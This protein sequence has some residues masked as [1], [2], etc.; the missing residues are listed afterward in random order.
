[1]RDE[2]RI[3]SDSDRISLDDQ[4]DLVCDEFE[5]LLRA[6]QSPDISTHVNAASLTERGR[7]FLELLLV[8]RDFRSDQGSCPTWDEYRQRYP[9]FAPQIEEARLKSRSTVEDET[10]HQPSPEGQ[11]RLGQFVLLERLGAGAVGEVWKARDAALQRDVAIKIPLD[12]NLS[13]YDLNRF[14]R[15]ARTAGQLNDPGIVAVYETGRHGDIVYIVSA[16]IPGQDLRLRLRHWT[17]TPREAADICRR[18]AESLQHAHDNGIVHRD[19][20]PSNIIVDNAARPHITDFGLA[21]WR[22]DTLAMTVE[23]DVMGTPAYMSPEQARGHAAN[24]DHRTDIYSLGM[25][26]YE[27]LTG[28]CAFSG[29]PEAIT[30]KVLNEEPISPDLMRRGLPRDLVT[31]CLKALAKSPEGRYRSAQEMA[32]DLRRFLDGEPILARRVGRVEKSWRWVRKRPA[33]VV[34]FGLALIAGG[35]SLVAQ[36][37]AAENRSL[38]GLQTVRLA[39]DPPAEDIV[40]VPYDKFTG[41]AAP[42][43]ATRLHGKGTVK[44]DLIPG[45]Y[46]VV[47]R[48]ADGRFHEV[49]RYVPRVGDVTLGHYLHSQWQQLNDGTIELPTINIPPHSVTSGMALV[50]AASHTTKNAPAPGLAVPAFYMDTHEFTEQQWEDSRD[51]CPALAPYTDARSAGRGPAFA[52]TSDL[53]NAMYSAELVG[54]RL[55]LLE[56]Y[57]AALELIPPRGRMLSADASKL[58]VI[59]PVAS[60]TSDATATMPPIVGL[61]SNVAE[62]T[63]SRLPQSRPIEFGT[64]GVPDDYR[65]LFPS[66]RREFPGERT[67]EPET[68]AVARRFTVDTRL[69]F[70]C[71]RSAAPRYLDAEK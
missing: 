29:K 26:L 36:H 43:R 24:A 8:D 23:G 68:R 17:P 11:Q 55:P 3:I 6:G 10:Q 13:E 54:K 2:S 57:E 9:E 5:Q 28:R 44:L 30:Y 4:I 49:V 63:T 16:F 37:T 15:E 51:G 39:T 35:A 48:T 65:I 34:A 25:I 27:M 62:W 67:D 21:K 1:M 56:E 58:D 69:G 61:L 22:E 70:R 50:D 7:L 52:M 46:L 59:G 38:L 32:V 31:V 41:E 64:I 33:V 60:D 42:S 12:R 53:D 71:V 18:I 19:L 66:A 40:F 14:L 45:E 20:K 47:A